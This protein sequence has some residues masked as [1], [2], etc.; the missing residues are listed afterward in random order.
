PSPSLHLHLTLLLESQHPSTH[1]EFLYL[2]FEIHTQKPSKNNQ[3]KLTKKT[4]SQP[5]KI[6]H[7]V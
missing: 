2:S 5:I 4:S 6:T 7:S 3:S 1:S